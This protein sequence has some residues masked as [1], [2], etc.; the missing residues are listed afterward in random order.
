MG[1]AGL[2]CE[3]P[4]ARGL[5]SK[6]KVEQHLQRTKW[7]GIANES[8]DQNASPGVLLVGHR[9]RGVL[10][11]AHHSAYR[12]ECGRHLPPGVRDQRDALSTDI[13]DYN[14]FVSAAANSV[15][16]LLALG[17]TWTAIASTATVDARDNTGTNPTVSTGV[18]IYRLDDTRIAD[19]NADLWDDTLQAAFNTTEDGGTLPP[20]NVFVWTGTD[21][22]GT[23]TGG[24]FGLGGNALLAT[25]GNA[26]STS[27]DWIGIGGLITFAGSE[28]T[29]PLYGL[30]DE[31]TVVPEP[32]SAV[33]AV[34][35]MVLFVG[36]RRREGRR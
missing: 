35:G 6:G 25:I 36:L 18:P 31:L 20:P 14:A 12:P 28:L 34:V 30:S 17:T 22:D 1:G 15:P 10:G 33:L 29:F 13:A 27:E 9:A 7:E 5:A 26:S 11:R 3:T 8:Q 19:D 2:D 16:E 4:N 23:G 21:G 32:S 24:G